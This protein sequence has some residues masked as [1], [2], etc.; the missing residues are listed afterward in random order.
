MTN[1]ASDTY[2]FYLKENTFIKSNFNPI[3]LTAIENNLNVILP[4]IEKEY[5]DA[6]EKYLKNRFVDSFRNILDEETNNLLDDFDYEQK[7][8]KEEL[9]KLFSE[10]IDNDL[11]E[12]NKNIHSTIASIWDYYMF[13]RTFSI[14]DKLSNFFALYANTTIVP[15]F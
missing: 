6:L 4:Q 9:D 3:I 11:H 8:L 7:R 12:V 15:L 10:K 13:I 2:T 1:I 5:N 14:P